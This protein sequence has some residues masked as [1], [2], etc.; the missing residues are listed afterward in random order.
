[1]SVASRIRSRVKMALAQDFKSI[2][3][4]NGRGQVEFDFLANSG[5]FTVEADNTLFVT[6]WSEA[7]SDSVHA[8]KDRVELLGIRP[9]ITAFPSSVEELEQFDFTRRSSVCSI[10]DVVVFMN[11]D[12]RFLAVKILDV[13]VRSRGANRK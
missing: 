5:L 13:Q 7:G 2:A 6:S 10:G 8:Y 4:V 1:M 3:D 9:G 11:Q 12:G